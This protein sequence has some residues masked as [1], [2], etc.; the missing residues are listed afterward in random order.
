MY[1]ASYNFKSWVEEMIVI[2]Y[3]EI[4]PNY[5]RVCLYILYARPA[6]ISRPDSYETGETYCL[7]CLCLAL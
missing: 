5:Q 6:Y 1:R 2:E 4:Y 3:K 7:Y